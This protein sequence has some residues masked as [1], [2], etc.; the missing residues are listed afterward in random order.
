MKQNHLQFRV[1]RDCGLRLPVDP[2]TLYGPTT[3]NTQRGDWA[4][5][6]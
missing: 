6:I 3:V 5:Q 4:V 1:S 2:W